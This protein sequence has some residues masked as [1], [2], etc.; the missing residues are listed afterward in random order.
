MPLA[1]VRGSRFSF[2]NERLRSNE[3]TNEWMAIVF[4]NDIFLSKWIFFSTLFFRIQFLSHVQ[5]IIDFYYLDHTL[6]L[7]LW[8]FFYF[9]VVFYP[10]IHTVVHFSVFH[11]LYWIKPLFKTI[12]SIKIDVIH[13][14]HRQH[15]HSYTQK[16]SELVNELKEFQKSSTHTQTHAYTDKWQYVSLQ[17]FIHLPSF[18]PH[19][20]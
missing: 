17:V 13:Y 15:I 4:V 19:S 5:H 2:L 14:F 10:T 6:S 9:F 11:C 16:Q 3:R 7:S 20:N 18:T 8:P 12:G 1:E